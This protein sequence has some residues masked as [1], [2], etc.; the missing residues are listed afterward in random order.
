MHQ[1]L[2]VHNTPKKVSLGF[3]ST[4][5]V[6]RFVILLLKK[7]EYVY[8]V[9]VY[10]FFFNIRVEYAKMLQMSWNLCQNNLVTHLSV[11]VT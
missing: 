3:V 10:Y 1:K 7:T 6:K 11:L 2:P 8:N 4:T 9:F 5:F